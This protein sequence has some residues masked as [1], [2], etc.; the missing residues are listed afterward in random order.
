MTWR[1]LY[2][3]PYLQLIE[4]QA[5]LRKRR[6]QVLLLFTRHRSERVVVAVAQPPTSVSEHSTSDSSSPIAV[7]VARLRRKRAPLQECRE[8]RRGSPGLHLERSLQMA[9]GQ[10]LGLR[11]GGLRLVGIDG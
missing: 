7:V 4:L 1:A 3:S 10:D 11:Y 5:L 8:Q 2:I 9:L 6:R